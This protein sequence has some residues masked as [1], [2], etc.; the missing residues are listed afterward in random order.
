MY[1][2]ACVVAISAANHPTY[3]FTNLPPTESAKALL[4]FAEL[5]RQHNGDSIRYRELPEALKSGSVAKIPSP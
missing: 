3:L 2:E 4:Q 5:Y 1:S